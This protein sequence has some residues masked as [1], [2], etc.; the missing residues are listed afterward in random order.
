MSVKIRHEQPLTEGPLEGRG[1]PDV[2]EDGRE[3]PPLV[4]VDEVVDV[5]DV[6][7]H[8]RF[9]ET[10][11]GDSGSHQLLERQ[12]PEH[13]VPDDGLHVVVV[14]DVSGDPLDVVEKDLL[15][16]GRVDRGE[17]L[18]LL[19]LVDVVERHVLAATRRLDRQRRR[20]ATHPVFAPGA[21]AELVDLVT[22]DVEVLDVRMKLKNL[23]LNQKWQFIKMST[24]KNT[25]TA[26][27]SCQTGN[28]YP[29]QV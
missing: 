16:R 7:P 4:A 26:S 25:S 27:L 11:G 19:E 5:L 1:R 17:V 18:Q 2:G 8:H 6:D 13:V 9:D 23:E 28:P 3:H 21:L 10:V 24:I 15:G 22:A 29:G 14:L 20:L 12:G